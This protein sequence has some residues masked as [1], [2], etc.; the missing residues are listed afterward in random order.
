MDVEKLKRAACD[1]IDSAADELNN[2]SQAIWKNPELNYEERHAH[3]VLTDLLEKHGLDVERNY[4]LDTAFRAVTG[5][6]GTGPHVAVI[7]EYDALPEIGHACGHNLI[8][9]VGVAA[10]LG[11]KAAF[12][13]AGKP[14]GKVIT[15]NALLIRTV[16]KN[17]FF[18]IRWCMNY[19]NCF[20]YK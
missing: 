18:P 8:A 17:Y 4:K 5:Q 14:I 7:C 2:L 3:K 20:M 9:E 19:Y 12:D 1:A 6:E 13:I 11:L 15:V 10:G 16:T